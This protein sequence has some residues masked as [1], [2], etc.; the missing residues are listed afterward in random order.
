MPHSYSVQ[1]PFWK[2]FL[3]KSLLQ[4]GV[5]FWPEIIIMCLSLSSKRGWYRLNSWNLLN[6]L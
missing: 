1:L 3:I 2:V 4:Q 5:L 6:N